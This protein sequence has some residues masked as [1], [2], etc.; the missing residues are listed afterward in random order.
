MDSP[1]TPTYGDITR[2]A[3][4]IAG[5]QDQIGSIAEIIQKQQK[6]IEVIDSVFGKHQDS[7]MLLHS[8]IVQIG[9]RLTELDKKKTGFF[10]SWWN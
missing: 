9:Q 10:S 1:E 3:K 8:L 4:A 5:M 6:A 2:I 7:M